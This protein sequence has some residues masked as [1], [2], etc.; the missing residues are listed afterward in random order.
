MEIPSKQPIYGGD[1]IN[2]QGDW[3]QSFPDGAE[4]IPAS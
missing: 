3:N 2:I 4:Y 1:L